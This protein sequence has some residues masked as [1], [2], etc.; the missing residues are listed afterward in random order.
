MSV[1]GQPQDQPRVET[2][3]A[4]NGSTEVGAGVSAILAAAEQA[5]EEIRADAR[6][7]AAELI[8]EAEEAVAARIQDLTRQGEKLREEAEAE[9]RDLRLAVEAYGK[10]RRREADSEATHVVAKAEGRAKE[11]L[12]EADKRADALAAE[13]TSRRQELQRDVERLE[14]LRVQVLRQLRELGSQIAQATRLAAPNEQASGEGKPEEAQEGIERAL[15]VG[16]P[17]RRRLVR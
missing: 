16:R 17:H 1:T 13:L 5:A 2:T 6:K 10:S 12:A 8:H 7:R 11:I 9:A 3:P 4:A 15:D 14:S